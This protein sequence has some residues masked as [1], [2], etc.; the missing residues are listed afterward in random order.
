MVASADLPAPTPDEN[1]PGISLRRTRP[2]V[3][4]LPGTGPDQGRRWPLTAYGRRRSNAPP[5]PT[6]RTVGTEGG[7]DLAVPAFRSS[8]AT[9][10]FRQI[11][12]W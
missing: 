12:A 6:W 7:S 1:L 2:L 8:Q 9:G 11:P 3:A 4:R 5:C 10:P